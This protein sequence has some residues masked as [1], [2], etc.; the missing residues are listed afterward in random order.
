[1][2]RICTFI[3]PNYF[4]RINIEDI[5]Y[6]YDNNQVYRTQYIAYDNFHC[7]LLLYQK[8]CTK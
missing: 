2:S 3:G 5:G 1:M 8:P 6:I 4:D 7:Y